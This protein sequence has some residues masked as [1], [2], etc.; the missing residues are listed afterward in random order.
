MSLRFS[1]L[2]RKLGE[3]DRSRVF[4]KLLRQYINMLV[5]SLILMMILKAYGKLGKSLRLNTEML[6]LIKIL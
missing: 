3:I 4:L 2:E 5:N 1:L 6:I